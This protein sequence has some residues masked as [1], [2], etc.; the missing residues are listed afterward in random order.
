LISNLYPN[1]D[2]PERIQDT[3]RRIDPVEIGA[4]TWPDQASEYKTIAASHLTPE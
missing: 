1:P 2:R 4:G 3:A